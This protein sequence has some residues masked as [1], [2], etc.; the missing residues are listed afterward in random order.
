MLHVLR[1]RHPEIEVAALL[2]TTGEADGHV[3]VHE[4]PRAL[5][6]AQAAATGLPAIEAPLPAERSNA[7][8]EARMAQGVAEARARFGITHV[9]FGDLF[10]EDIRRYRERQFAGSGLELVFPL[11]AIETDSLAR[12]MIAGGLKARLVVVDRDRLDGALAG[13]LF[14][15]A[16]LADLPPGVD[17][18]GENGEFHSFAFD[19]PMFAR[20]VAHRVLGIDTGARF[21]TARL[22]EADP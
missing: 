17:P 4:T 5:R 18:C 21:V 15:E 14:D 8:Y 10:L 20:S 12:E 3:A 1:T 11:W 7:I 19:G 16:L 22:A 13:R 9:A 6:L 2:T